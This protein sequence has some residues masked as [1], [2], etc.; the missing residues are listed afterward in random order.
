MKLNTNRSY[1]K[2][3]LPSS[4]HILRAIANHYRRCPGKHSCRSNH[5]G[6]EY[7]SRGSC[8][9]KLRLIIILLS[10]SGHRTESWANTYSLRRQHSIACIF[11]AFQHTTY[12][13]REFIADHRGRPDFYFYG[14]AVMGLSLPLIV[15]WDGYRL[16][17]Y[18]CWWVSWWMGQY[19]S[20]PHFQG[21]MLG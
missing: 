2:G 11:G 15:S 19:C 14:V 13:I 21:C 9:T 17:E 7:I 10:K 6:P 12:P 4:L 20:S 3:S 5:K 8:L 18:V 16:T 1:L